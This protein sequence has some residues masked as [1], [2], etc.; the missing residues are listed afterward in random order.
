MIIIII[1]I[2]NNDIYILKHD[3]NRSEVIDLENKIETEMLKFCSR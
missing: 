3:F 2:Y 1:K